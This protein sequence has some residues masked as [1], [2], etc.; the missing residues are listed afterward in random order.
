MAKGAE[1]LSE[2]QLAD[3]VTYRVNE[4][5][6]GTMSKSD[7]K[8]VIGAFKEEVVDCLVN[9]YK[10]KLNGL[11]SFEA[12][13]VPEKKKGEPVRNPATGETAPRAKTTPAGFKGSVRVSPSIKS[14][15]P[16]TKSSNGRELAIKLVGTK[17]ARKAGVG[18]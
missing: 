2:S 10:V 6:G 15:F 4:R 7:V 17:A 9:G 1:A 3:L 12:K 14:K 8:R 18:V 16:A 5:D 11:A 13:L